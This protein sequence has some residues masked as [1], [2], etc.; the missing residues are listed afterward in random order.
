[1][2]IHYMCNTKQQTEVDYVAEFLVCAKNWKQ[3]TAFLRNEGVPGCRVP[4]VPLPELAK[5]FYHCDGVDL[6]DAQDP[7]V[8]CNG[9]ESHAFRHTPQS[10]ID[11]MREADE[12]YSPDY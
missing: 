3:I 8:I 10:A 5:W 2:E 12:S 4:N 6:L 9:Y 7:R 11:T 1:M